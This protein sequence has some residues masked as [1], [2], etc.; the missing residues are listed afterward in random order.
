MN[1][2]SIPA[3][4]PEHLELALNMANNLIDRFSMS[5]Q[6]EAIKA[7]ERR[8]IEYRQGELTQHQEACKA[9]SASLDV[10]G[11]HKAI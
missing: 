1:E 11:Q 5:Q 9:I 6:N 2:Q 8:I 4:I 3:T 10:L 7:I